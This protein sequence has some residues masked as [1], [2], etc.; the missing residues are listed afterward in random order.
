MTST[1][2][3][4]RPLRSDSPAGGSEVAETGR[5]T[6]ASPTLWHI[7][8]DRLRILVASRVDSGHDPDDPYR[9]LYV[10]PEAALAMASADRGDSPVA[11]IEPELERWA[12][13]AG[14]PGDDGVVPAL[15]QRLA[16]LM[17]RIGADVLDAVI[18]L[19]AAAPAL[20]RRLERLFGFLNDDVTRRSASIGLLIELCG[21]TDVGS[22]VRSRLRPASPLLRSD[23]IE[24]EGEE[25]PSFL[26][27]SV[28]VHDDVVAYLAGDGV[29]Q[30]DLP[31]QPSWIVD[32]CAG[33]AP[34]GAVDEVCAA[35]RSG[36]GLVYCRLSSRT[37]MRAVAVAAFRAL[38]TD[39][40]SIA[41][42]QVGGRA[43]DER[44]ARTLVRRA[45]LGGAGLV[46][47]PIEPI[48]EAGGG[49]FAELVD[50]GAPM[51][52]AG[53]TP[54]DARWSERVPYV[55]EPPLV[56]T[57]DA[58]R[59]VAR[60]L[61]ALEAPWPPDLDSWDLSQFS[62]TPDG[63]A[64][65]VG[66]AWVRARSQ[67]R[68]LGLEDVAEGV[69]LN[70]A[71]GLNRLAQRVRP[72][73]HWDAL[74]VDSSTL[75]HLRAL[76]E[77]VRLRYEVTSGRS[78]RGAARVSGVVALFAGD[79][80]TGKTLAAEIIANELNLDLYV[81]NLATVVDK[82][83]G[84][85]EKNLEAIFSQAEGV[86]GVLFFDEADALFGKR[87]E[88][89]DAHDRYAN[90]EVA[91]LLQRIG[92]FDGLVVLATNLRGNMDP[93]FV[94]RL[95]VI[96]HFSAPLVEERRALWSRYLE[97]HGSIG[98]DVDLDFLA[99][100]FR[101]SG[102]AIEN[103]CLTAAFEARGGQGVIS[104][105]AVVRATQRELEKLGRFSAPS[106][107]GP[108]ASLLDDRAVGAVVGDGMGGQ[109]SS[110]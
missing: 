51:V 75:A 80:G 39:V 93:A 2:E 61:D 34:Q 1:E 77:R 90:I 8:G 100:N 5:A 66:T 22:R 50:S 53:H 9:G 73:A 107:F 3:S 21:H 26:R 108:Y 24:V 59:I 10:T 57:D 30:E 4:S 23:L 15:E 14:T 72:R 101:L 49:T 13:W 7:I 78:E 70:N 25:E 109:T 19:V 106:E 32:V 103:A 17:H 84:E 99:E 29:S 56:G 12:R 62:L 69:R 28:R 76:T 31:A 27:R 16:E 47:A 44:L 110:P 11:P 104:M 85:T 55:F 81:V 86:N 88:G 43:L 65:A 20:E 98:A 92:T 67:G 60:S 91:Y 35:L 18:V 52:L 89:G 64:R 33:V 96:V 87:S 38:G 105:A 102:G 45:L 97:R 46:V 37:M 48:L 95:D 42:D 74:I 54:W 58:R 71:S 68:V 6:A 79:P 82:Y 63:L 41:A 36:S 83:V 40:I 94:R